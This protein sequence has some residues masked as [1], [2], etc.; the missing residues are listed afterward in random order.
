MKSVSRLLLSV[1]FLV[2]LSNSRLL[3]TPLERTVS[4]SRQFIVYGVNTPLRGAV[5]GVA[6]KTKANLLKLLQQRDEWVTPIILNLQFPQANLPDIPAAALYFSQTGSGLKLQ[7]DLTIPA[8][9]DVLALRRELLR[10]ILLEMIYRRQPDLPAGTVFVEPPPWLVEGVLATG[11]LQDRTELA[12][13]VAPM[14]SAKKIISLEEFVRQNPALL[15]SAGQELHRAYSLVLLELLLDAPEGPARLAA[16]IGNLSQSL[17]DPFANL[18]AQFPVLAGATDLE[19]LWQAK[20]ASMGAAHD[21]ELLT[22]AETEQRL[23]VLL[24]AG[25]TNGSENGQRIR[26]RDLL[27]RK[28]SKAQ[29]EEVRRLGQDLM[30]LSA[31]AN[32]VWRPAIIEYQ[33]VLELLRRGKRKGL[34]A[35][36]ARIESKRRAMKERMS[37]I[38]D[39]MN[40]FEATKSGTS[41]GAFAAFHKAA[42]S[43]TEERPRRHDPLSVYLDALEEEF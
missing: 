10:A 5:A 8:D 40:W 4:A 2:L 37:D 29:N 22:F 42:A 12:E 13:A 3:A 20:V 31:R 33:Q 34:E 39:Y 7:L 14:V 1:G 21:Y 18:K 27:S 17:P 30:V 23:D 36:F 41:S 43:V 25:I 9:L 11:P 32:P 26:L 35:R 19:G 16:Y 24:N 15:D 38:D 6:E 28:I